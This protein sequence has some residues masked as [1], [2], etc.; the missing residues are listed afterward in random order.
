MRS[1]AICRHESTNTDMK[2]EYKYRCKIEYRIQ[3]Q[4]QNA[5][6]HDM[7]RNVKQIQ[8]QEKHNSHDSFQHESKEV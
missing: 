4:M 3:I 5:S 1:T 7:G 8:I 6:R 2:T